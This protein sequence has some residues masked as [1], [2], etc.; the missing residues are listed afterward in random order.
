MHGKRSITLL[1]FLLVALFLSAT[2][3][4]IFKVISQDSQGLE[5]EFN[6]PKYE[7]G[8]VD[9][10]HA[11]YQQIKMNHEIYTGEEGQPE[12]PIFSTMIEIPARG[13]V[14]ANLELNAQSSQSGLNIKRYYNKE[15]EA[16]ALANQNAFYPSANFQMSTPAIWRDVRVIP[17]NVTPFRFNTSTGELEVV[18][19]GTIRISFDQSAQ[20]ENELTLNRGQSSAFRNIYQANILNYQERD[21]RTDDPPSI[22]YV[23]NNSLNYTSYLKPLVDWKH[24]QGFEVFTASTSQ[25]GTTTTSIRNYLQN[26]YET[27]SN[28][29]DFFVL[30]GDTGGTYGLP[31]Y[32]ISYYSA[33]GDHPYAL[34]SGN[35]ELE[36]VFM[37]RIS[38]SSEAELAV[39]V[40][41]ILL[42]EK[43]QL[44]PA[45]SWM[46]ANLLVGDTDPSGISCISGNKYM[47]E[48]MDDYSDDFTYT[49]LYGAGP[50]S[51]TMATTLNNGVGYF[52][53]RG[54]IG[55]SGF[56]TTTI[57]GLTNTAKL[58]ICINITCSTGSYA[59]T[60]VTEAF[61]RAGSVAQPKGA[62]A[63]I[64][65]ST[66]GTHT[67]YNN[68]LDGGIISGLFVDDME[69]IGEALNKGKNYLWANYGVSQPETAS[70][71]MH[72]CNLMGDPSLRAWKG[73]PETM[74]VTYPSTVST[75]TGEI[76]VQVSGGGNDLAGARVTALKGDDEIFA[77]GTT[78]ENGNISLSIATGVSGTVNLTVTKPGY[79]PHMGTF[80]LGNTTQ[81][82]RITNLSMQVGASTVTSLQPGNTAN[83]TIT[84]E[85]NGTSSLDVVNCIITPLS[86][87]VT[88]STSSVSYSSIA[89]GAT[90][91]NTTPFVVYLE[92][93]CYPE[94]IEFVMNINSIGD[95]FTRTFSLPVQSPSLIVDSWMVS[96]TGTEVMLPGQTSDIT[97][98]LRNIGNASFA[99]RNLLISSG[100][101]DITFPD[102]TATVSSIAANGTANVTFNITAA[103]MMIPGTIA[104]MNIAV[105][106]GGFDYD[107]GFSLAVGQPAV[108]DPLGPDSHGYYIYDMDDTRYDLAP[109]Y[110]WIGIAPSEGGSGTN[111]GLND[112]GNNADDVVT[113]N[114]PFS[115]KLYGESYSQITVCSNGWIAGG[116][117]EQITFR[118]WRIPGAVGPSPMIAP[119]WDD[120]QMGSGDVYGYYN[121]SQHY[122]VVE[123][124]NVQ[125]YNGSAAETFQAIIYDETYY[126]TPTNDC[127]IKFQ[128]NTFNNV[129]NDTS[130]VHGEYSTIGIES[131]D[132]SMGLEYTFNN[133]Y[134][135]SCME[136]GNNTA[137]YITTELPEFVVETDV[138][139]LNNTISDQG[140]SAFIDPGETATFTIDITNLG[141]QTATGVVAT[142]SEN[143]PY[144]TISNATI[145]VGTLAYNDTYQAEFQISVSASTPTGHAVPL[146]LSVTGSP[147]VSISENYAFSVG[148]I[149]ETYESG[150]FDNMDWEFSGS[151][152]WTVV[153][154]GAYNGTYCAKSGAITHSQETDMYLIAAVGTAGDISFYSRVS[155]E[156]NY[157]YLRFYIDGS[158][159]DDWSGEQG[160]ALH[161]YPVSTGSHTFKWTYYKDSIESSG[162]DCAWVDDITFPPLAA[163]VPM[164]DLS[165][166]SI[167]FGNVVQGISSARQFII[168][169][170]GTAALMGTIATPT[171]FT[172]SNVSRGYK[173]NL[174]SRNTINFTV[175]ALG[176]ESY[177]V[178]FTPSSTI[179]YSGNVVISHNSA[180]GTSNVAVSGMG[181]MPNIVVNPLTVEPSMLPNDQGGFNLAINNT[182]VGGL[183]YSIGIQDA[184]RNSGGPDAYGYEWTDSREAGG[185]TYNWV[186]ISTVGTALSLGDDN[187]VSVDLPFN[188]E[189]YGSTKSSVDICS[190]GYLTFGTDSSD[191]SN[192]PIPSATDPDDIIAPMWDDLKPASAGGTGT[193]YHYYDS[194]NNR[195]IVEY[196][197]VSHYYANSGNETCQVILYPSGDILYQYD[198]TGSDSDYTI[199]IENSNGSDGLQIAYNSAFGLNDLAILIS[200]NTVPEWL[201]TTT[202][203]G[204][205]NPGTPASIAFS[206][207]T[208]DLPLG[209]YNKNIVI[210]SNDPD[211]GTVSV[212]VTLTVTNT[213]SIEIPVDITASMEGTNIQLSWS[214]VSGASSYKIYASEDPYAT[215]WG[216]PI[217]VISSNSWLYFGTSTTM[218]FFRIV[219]SSS[220]ARGTQLNISK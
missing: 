159:E 85:N 40:N 89:S 190:N 170:F 41:K 164:I 92:D 102:A 107:M 163:P 176:T 148:I 7:I 180:A 125:N 15:D 208:T 160:W 108:V 193:V 11:T 167:D 55:M 112:S 48:V 98:T 87:N 126:P 60:A 16:V 136:L 128:Y 205:V 105:N 183:D 120:L 131:H 134:P 88:T 80:T 145:S 95:D 111:L 216:A 62:V 73:V 84:L 165:T 113:V 19:R 96:G 197:N 194:A 147:A 151:Q 195:F 185:P 72:L 199:G 186:E 27:W 137:L 31:Y 86:D 207:D 161:T 115:L 140:G 204:S 63:A 182:G 178:N 68:C 192:D 217:A 103:A 171:G 202:T 200:D 39:I 220:A 52:H 189:F 20:G 179:Q 175:G 71:F 56:N 8:D 28:P 109:D 66:P 24:Q 187:G 1:L 218:K 188:F 59:D 154:S 132:E 4:D 174:R 201:S 198:S 139:T 138:R 18:E 127:P 26:A 157:D 212:P 124:Y 79:T 30:V 156:G 17:I 106:S 130:N 69:T 144:V 77:T 172:V 6:L 78:D 184:T 64:G 196:D 82:A 21:V 142:L 61:I 29:P 114:M 81:S 44:F 117:T 119:F 35:D 153:S 203:S 177:S 99:S 51:S 75:T 5:I 116:V 70:N 123:W 83:L 13:T 12:L 166:T 206:I 211:N 141:L 94:E 93:T 143:D 213:P 65:M 46:D 214:A 219:A 173:E 67:A 3:T 49:E 215:N 129:D 9:F 42:Y 54:W 14:S 101:A 23:Y 168:T 36:D 38:F 25:T 149:M 50:S 43:N 191:Y 58:P 146:A 158:L 209:V 76:L 135:A 122:Y 150:N 32:Q 57:S 33:E 133:I 210:T 181:V 152:P 162:S 110:N 74:T 34:I 121:S 45:A 10:N 37:G 2:Q 118:N 97:V 169:N 155:S 90:I 53:Y 22:L 47:K 104:P 91:A 100:S